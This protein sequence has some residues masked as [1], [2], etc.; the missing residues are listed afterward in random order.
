M[1]KVRKGT[2]NRLK[3]KLK[4]TMTMIGFDKE[5]LKHRKNKNRKKPP[6]NKL[7]K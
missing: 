4:L 7:N 3:K 1:V 6:I 5:Q 2:C